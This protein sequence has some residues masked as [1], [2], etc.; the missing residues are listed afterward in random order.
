[1]GW[2]VADKFTFTPDRLRALASAQK[3]T[4][5]YDSKIPGL[6]VIV[7]AKS[8]T[9]YLYRRING[10]PR[11]VRLG[12]F[13]AMGVRQAREQASRFNAEVEAGTFTDRPRAATFGAIHALYVE[14]AKGR[15]KTW[16][17]ADDLNR[18]YLSDWNER[19]ILEITYDLVAAKHAAVGKASPAVANRL[20]SAVSG[21]FRF[22]AQNGHISRTADNPAK[23]IRRFQEKARKRFLSPDELRR[24]FAAVERMTSRVMADFFLMLLFT[25]Q[26]SGKVKSMRWSDITLSERLWR[27]ATNKN[28]EEITIHLTP[29]AIE[30][31]ERRDQS[32]EWVFPAVNRKSGHIT[33][34]QHAW[35]ELLEDADISDFRIHDLRH[36]MASWQAINGSSLTVIGSSLG[37]RSHAST[38]RYAHVSLDAVRAS[39]DAAAAKMVAFKDDAQ[40]DASVDT[41]DPVAKLSKLKK[42]LAAEL[43]TQA[44]YDEAKA[45]VLRA[46]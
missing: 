33:V 37:H 41:S 22:A 29:P 1:M 6:I 7:T 34:T 5:Y 36:T 2:V 21:V 10:K 9:F 27:I 11:R 30:I 13:P 44:D 31:L 12:R 23:G 28:G 39:V 45:K 4:T 15:I 16:R 24:W 38:A 17:D 3:P 32:S 14:D 25:G 20:L 35:A 26:R 43:I 42:L 19:P 40:A 8:K 18:L 46:I